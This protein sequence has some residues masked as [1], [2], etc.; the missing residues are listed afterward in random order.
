MNRYQIG[1]RWKQRGDTLIAEAKTRS[2]ALAA[3]EQIVTELNAKVEEL[4]KELES[5]RAKVAELEKKVSENAGAP[6]GETAA[7][8]ADNAELVSRSR[9]D[10]T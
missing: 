2:E 9:L 1:I 7:P 6:S 8:A 3:Q 10:L 5:A 4:G